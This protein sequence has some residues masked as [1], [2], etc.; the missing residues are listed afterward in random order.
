MF[1]LIAAFWIVGCMLVCLVKN[2]RAPHLF[3]AC[4]CLAIGTI[5]GAIFLFVAGNNMLGSIILGIGLFL[6][7]LV[8]L[9]AFSKKMD[10]ETENQH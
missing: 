10:A 1:Y 6:T 3:L 9:A 8:L 4:P 2:A 7:M 5:L